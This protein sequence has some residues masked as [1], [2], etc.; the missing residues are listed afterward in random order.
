VTTPTTV[1]V[2]LKLRQDTS[3]GWSAVN[4][5]LLVGELGRESNTGK[6]KI[7]D[8]STAWNSLTYQP[9]GALITNDDISA[10][11]EIAV[12]KLADGAARQILQTDAAGTGVEWASNI[13]IPGTLDVTGAATFDATVTVTGDLTV[14]GTTTTI[15]TQNLL[16]ED[17]N[18]IIGDVATPTDT[19]AD[20][21]GITL[22]GA[23]DK[24]INWIDATDAWTSSERFSIPLGSAAAPSLTINGDAN[25]G[26][27]SPGAD[28]VAISTG[29]SGRLFVDASGNVILGTTSVLSGAGGRVLQIGN[30][31]DAQSTL[32][33]AATTAGNS[34][35]QFGDGGSP[36]SYA[37][38]LQY[39]HTDNVFAIGT[40]SNERLRITSAGLVGIGTT[41]PGYLLQ[42]S[43]KFAVD[44]SNTFGRIYLQRQTG[45]SLT[46]M[47]IQ[48]ADQ[49]NTASDLAIVNTSGGG[50]A[51]EIAGG[52][53]LAAIKFFTNGAT[54]E[55][56]RID[57]SGRFLVGTSTAQGGAKLQVQDGEV[58]LRRSLSN[59]SINAAGIDLGFVDF[60]NQDGGVGAQILA[61]ADAAWG[62]ND[63]PGR[64]VFSTTADG[65]STP[66]E[67]M[68]IKA[69]GATCIG[70]STEGTMS[71]DTVVAIGPNIGIISK[72]ASGVATS[73]TV[74]I[75]INTGGGGYQ[76]FL[77]VSNTDASNGSV[78]THTTF[79]VFGRG[80]DSS[81]QQIATDNGTT[82]GASFTVTTP[83]NGVI[84]VTNTSAGS[85]TVHIQFFGGTSF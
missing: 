80:T 76:G 1:K 75:N 72:S 35:I 56:A 53:S 49:A 30:T 20:G 50:S 15:S 16:V 51:I 65:A 6:I 41:S 48:G 27:Y 42:V 83:T 79:S 8:G 67:R 85:R 54:T 84:R 82:S 4:P 46:A 37:G 23:T 24:T 44:N 28:Q 12:S 26:L 77:V 21:G 61:E 55:R 57:F 13:D 45:T 2:Q 38:Y 36:G 31:S 73:G 33:F 70:T 66:T 59:A 10:T 58:F 62:T 11:A 52:T 14:N 19:T 78:R 74:D 25:S 39:T 69:N 9:F 63:Y 40:A 47:Y 22:K 68:R 29:G 60:G 7:G 3:S 5:I 18:I 34:Q 71:G 17:K 32:Q 64:L 81:I 43:D